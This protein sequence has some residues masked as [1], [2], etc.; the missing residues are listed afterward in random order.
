MQ[1]ASRRRGLALIELVYLQRV[2]EGGGTQQSHGIIITH[3][4]FIIQWGKGIWPN[5]FRNTRIGMRIN[6]RAINIIAMARIH[7]SKRVSFS[8]FFHLQIRLE[9]IRTN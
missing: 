6:Y 8:F 4:I 3:K 7:N 1:Q 5:Q 2:M 9:I